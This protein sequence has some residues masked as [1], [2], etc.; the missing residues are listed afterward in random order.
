MKLF[1]KYMFGL[2]AIAAFATTIVSCSDDMGINSSYSSHLKFTVKTSNNWNSSGTR[3]TEDSDV[4]APEFLKLKDEK[5]TLNLRI[6]SDNFQEGKNIKAIPD[7]RSTIVEASSFYNSFGVSAYS[8]SDSWNDSNTPNLMYNKEM[9]T[10]GDF[11]VSEADYWPNS[12]KVRF[13]AYAPYENTHVRM[14]SHS[15]DAGAP[16]L[17]YTVPSNVA[18]QQDLLVASSSDVDAPQE[19]PYSLTFNH[20][21]TAVKFAVGDMKAGTIQ[22][23]TISGVYGSGIYDFNTG[24]WATSGSTSSYSVNPNFVTDGTSQNI[25]VTDNELTMLMM[26]QTLGPNAQIAVT[27]KFQD[28]SIN[29]LT[30]GIGGGGRSWNKGETVTYTISTSSLNDVLLITQPSSFTYEGGSHEYKVTSYKWIGNGNSKK[31]AW[32]AKFYDVNGNEISKPSWLTSFTTSGEGS[33]N[34]TSFTAS[35]SRQEGSATTHNSLLQSNSIKGNNNDSYDLSTHDYYGNNTSMTTANCYIVNA[36]GYYKLPLVYG[37][38]I[39]NGEDNPSGYKSDCTQPLILRNM[40]DSYD[41]PITSPYIYDK[42]TPASATLIWQDSQ[43]L[44]TGVDLSDSRNGKYT[45]LKFRVNKATIKEGNA[46]VAVKDASGHILWSWHIWVTD[47]DVTATKQIYNADGKLSRFMPIY[48]GWCSND[49]D[50]TYYPSRNVIVKVTQEGGITAQFK[51]TQEYHFITSSVYGYHTFYQWGRKDPL[52]PLTDNSTTAM[53][54]TLYYS[55][56]AYT[57]S[58]VNGQV[59]VGTSIATPY[60]FRFNQSGESSYH[61]WSKEHY[62]NL[63]NNWAAGPDKQTIIKTIYDPSPRGFRLPA[64]NSLSAFSEDAIV[65]PW[66]NGITLYCNINNKVNGGTF[67]YPASGEWNGGNGL[68]TV[69]GT[70]GHIWFGNPGE[71]ELRGTYVAYRRNSSAVAAFESN[72][73]SYSKAYG[74]GI[75]AVVDE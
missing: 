73:A 65:G 7:T 21:L 46:V 50:V 14:Y 27:Y 12:G 26:P 42:Y 41:Q 15:S 40:V 63:W 56:S 43:N 75:F 18:E 8:F 37:N 6:T 25:I 44:I 9:T 61:E 24:A 5:L 39:K 55:N 31:V 36:Y 32:T 48:L 4:N 69:A 71:S 53:P 2:C 54:R 19:N 13:Y 22:K 29:T 47:E 51:I 57:F 67:Y 59:S 70:M 72:P 66:N 49:N 74:W 58:S 62:Q 38:A 16:K 17:S 68:S 60:I 35:V 23:I 3:S 34:S 10:N 64:N 33:T 30:A 1:T 28:G 45:Y 52:P 20:V 11:Y